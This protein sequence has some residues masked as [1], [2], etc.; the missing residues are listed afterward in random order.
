MILILVEDLLFLSKIEQTARQVGVALEAV[1]PQA[2]AERVAQGAVSGVIVDLN[3]R[4]GLALGVVQALKTSP[5]TRRFR[6]VGFLSHVQADLAASA[7]EAGWDLVLPRSAFSQR[8]PRLLEELAGKGS[9]G[10][11]AS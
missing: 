11:S 8:L 4:S 5:S 10:A 3:H 1:D 2:A 9:G 7:R 6:I